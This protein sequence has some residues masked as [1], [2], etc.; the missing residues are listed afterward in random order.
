MR[1]V[2]SGP[3]G[4][5]DANLVI[6]PQA[7]SGLDPRW[8]SPLPPGIGG[9]Q[10]VLEPDGT[11]FRTDARPPRGEVVYRFRLEGLRRGRE[12]RI[13]FTPTVGYTNWVNL[14]DPTARKTF[15][16]GQFGTYRFTARKGAQDFTVRVVGY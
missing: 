7:A 16:P 8:D 2:A 9:F 15:R 14:Y 12:Y 1:M 3:D 13:Q 11:R 4:E 10:L 6:H 5:V